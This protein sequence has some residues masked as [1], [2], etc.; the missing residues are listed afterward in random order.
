MTRTDPLGGRLQGSYH[1]RGVKTD[2]SRIQRRLAMIERMGRR[3][4]AQS[5]RAGLVDRMVASATNYQLAVVSDL[6]AALAFLAFGLHRFVGPRSMAGG[7]V[8]LGFLSCGL[9]EYAVHRW[10][11]HGPPLYRPARPCAPPRS[12]RGACCRTA[13]HD[14]DR[15]AG[16]LDTPCSRVGRRSRRAS[17]LWVV[18]RVQLTS[19]FCTI[20]NTITTPTS[21]AARPGADLTDCTTSITSDRAST[22][23]SA[24]HSGTAYSARFSQS[25]RRRTTSRSSVAASP[26]DDAFERVFGVVDNRKPTRGFYTRGI[27]PRGVCVGEHGRMLPEARPHARLRGSRHSPRSAGLGR[28]RDRRSDAG[29]GCGR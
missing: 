14:R 9:L 5:G 17:G 24:R 6:M 13:V 12:A 16:D 11:L 7:I 29:D 22:L 18:R 10:V 25:A 28:G 3:A 26:G 23:A 15:F 8:L 19:L 1:E 21:R 27:G 20:G 4:T 2:S